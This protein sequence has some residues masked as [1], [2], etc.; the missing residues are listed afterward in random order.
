MASSGATLL[1]NLTLA[2]KRAAVVS[3]G[4]RLF[5]PVPRASPSAPPKGSTEGGTVDLLGRPVAK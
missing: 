1:A 5:P 3:A 2:G 4:R